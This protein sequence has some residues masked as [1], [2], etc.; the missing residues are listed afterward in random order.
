MK[1]DLLSLFDL[2]PQQIESLLKRAI[3]LKKERLRHRL[4]TTL[5][6][7]TLAMIFE[8]S[9]TRTRLSFEIAMWELGGFAVYLESG[10]TQLGRGESYTDT[11][12]VLS[13]YA[14]GIL[15]RTYG[16][17][18]AEE[19]ARSASIP[20]INGL[21]D[22][23]HPCQVLADLMTIRECKKKVQKIAY[24]GDGNNMANSW[25][26]AAL[27]LKIP[28]SV[29]TPKGYG[30]AVEILKIPPGDRLIQIT[31]DPQEAVRGAD[32]VNTDTWFS[33]GQ[34]VEEKKRIAFKPFQVNQQLL[35]LAKPD[36]IVLHCLPAHRGEEITDEVMEGRQSRIWEEAGNR[37]PIQ[38]AILEMLLK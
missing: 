6:G 7:R 3:Q 31:E 15:I 9:S 12:R 35:K 37:L 27:L 20:V 19:L 4:R 38:K 16:H 24:V 17:S 14:H 11:A 2:T 18:I 21:T 13:R 10:T 36:A 25:I 5:K 23:H 32:V 26:Q 28:L 29:A 30:P 22:L 34:E 33:M 1:K 8:K